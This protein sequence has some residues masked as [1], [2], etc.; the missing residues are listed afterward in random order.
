[1]LSKGSKVARLVYRVLLASNIRMKDNKA[2]SILL[3]FT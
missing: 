2:I 3:I 1:M